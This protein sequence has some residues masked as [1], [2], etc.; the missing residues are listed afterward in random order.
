VYWTTPLP[1]TTRSNDSSANRANFSP[2]AT[3]KLAGQAAVARSSREPGRSRTAGQVD[4]YDRLRRLWQNRSQVDTRRPQ[5]DLQATRR[6]RLAI[7]IDQPQQ[8]DA[9][10]RK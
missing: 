8:I 4:T 9:A 5:A 10:S 6:P 7:E 1:R 3:W 2:S